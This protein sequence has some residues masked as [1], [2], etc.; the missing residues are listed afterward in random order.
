MHNGDHPKT[1]EDVNFGPSL[2][3]A[4]RLHGPEGRPYEHTRVNPGSGRV[5]TRKPVEP[6][7]EQI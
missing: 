5:E 4:R 2:T 7:A 1:V 3:G 6:K